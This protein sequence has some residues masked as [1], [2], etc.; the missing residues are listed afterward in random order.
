MIDENVVTAIEELDGLDGKSTDTFY[1]KYKEVCR[2]SNANIK[3]K[4][5][6]VKQ[7]KLA[8]YELDMKQIVSSR[9]YMVKRE[10]DPQI[11]K[12]A[13]DMEITRYTYYTDSFYDEYVEQCKQ[14]GVKPRDKRVVIRETCARYGLEVKREQH[15]EKT[16]KT[17]ISLF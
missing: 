9:G 14:D 6:A 11:E 15:V 4:S 7:A 12:V 16:V 13:H 2:K 10:F 5:Y 1:K 3:A 17:F 8:G